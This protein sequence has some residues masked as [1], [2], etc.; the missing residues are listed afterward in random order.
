MLSPQAYIRESAEYIAAAKAIDDDL[1][2]DPG[3]EV[4]SPKPCYYTMFHG[5]ELAA[6][7]V[8]VQVGWGEKQLKAV[9]HN[10]CKAIEEARA[11]GLALQ[12]T[13]DQERLLSLLD[14]YYKR[15]R[16]PESGEIEL[17]VWGPL[18]DLMIVILK[19]AMVA[20]PGGE[21]AIRTEVLD[22]LTGYAVW[23]A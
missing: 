8:L 18:I 17:P 16:Y 9:S 1:G 14:K 3:Y 22:R 7:A 21:A 10:L 6:K 4:L 5:V 15:L 11:C 13:P 23:H 12:L 20:V 19:A 2:N